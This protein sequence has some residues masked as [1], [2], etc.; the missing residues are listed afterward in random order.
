MPSKAFSEV[1][2]QHYLG[3]KRVV[4][5]ATVGPGGAPFAMPMWFVQD[6][7]HLAM[8]SVDGLAKI[9]NLEREPRVCVVAEGGT[10][11]EID[12]VVLTGAVRFVDGDERARWGERFHAKYAPRVE[13]LWGGSTLPD[14]RRVFVLRPRVAAAWGL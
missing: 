11:G 10:D 13:R 9:R 8:V 14:D 1:A 3:A 7:E 12:G 5:L 4:V 6:R 2:V